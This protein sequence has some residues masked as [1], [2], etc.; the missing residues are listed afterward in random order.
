MPAVTGLA[1]RQN[2]GYRYHE[3]MLT[4]HTLNKY[5]LIS[6]RACIALR[7]IRRSLRLRLGKQTLNI[8]GLK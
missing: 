6:A 8:P 7:A 4:I 2:I 3:I 1:Y 5:L